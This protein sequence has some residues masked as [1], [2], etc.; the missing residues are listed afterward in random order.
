[1]KWKAKKCLRGIKWKG[2]KKNQDKGE[3]KSVFKAERNT[4]FCCWLFLKVWVNINMFSLNKKC[5][6]FQVIHKD[7]YLVLMDVLASVFFSL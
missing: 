1:M 3:R 4:H 6:Q 7:Y 5:A 2:G